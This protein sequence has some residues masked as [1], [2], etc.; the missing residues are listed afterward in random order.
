MSLNDETSDLL[1][2]SSGEVPQQEIASG[3]VS[4]AVQRQSV[5]N[6]AVVLQKYNA[7]T[8]ASFES[9]LVS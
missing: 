6:A 4:H 7:F 1:G 5:S 2:G 8:M 3:E 9:S